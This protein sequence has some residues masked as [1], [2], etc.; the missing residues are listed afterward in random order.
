MMIVLAR[1]MSMPF[2]MIV[3]ATK[4]SY[5]YAT[6]SS[7]ICSISFSFICPC[8]TQM[9]AF[10]TMRLMSPA[11]ESI[12]STRLC[13]KKICPFRPSWRRVPDSSARISGSFQSHHDHPRLLLSWAQ[14][15]PSYNFG[16][17]AQFHDH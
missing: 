2:S 17:I 12:V 4:I 5:L 11:I 10:G 3:V 16:N 6:K 1:G 7:M 15:R 13:M 9:R 8:A 14:V